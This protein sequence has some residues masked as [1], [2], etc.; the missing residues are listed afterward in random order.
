MIFLITCCPIMLPIIDFSPARSV[1][2]MIQDACAK[3]MPSVEVRMPGAQLVDGDIDELTYEEYERSF[4]RKDAERIERC[5]R[6]IEPNVLVLLPG[7]A[8]DVYFNDIESGLSHNVDVWDERDAAMFDS[9][10]LHLRFHK[11]KHHTSIILR[12]R[13]EW[14]PRSK[15]M[16][17]VTTTFATDNWNIVF[18][19]MYAATRE[20]NTLSSV[21]TYMELCRSGKFKKYASNKHVVEAINT[22]L[23]HTRKH[24]V[25]LPDEMYATY[26]NRPPTMPANVT[27]VSEAFLSFDPTVHDLVPVHRVVDSSELEARYGSIDRFPILEKE[28]PISKWYGFTE[29]QIVRIDRNNAGVVDTYYRR[30]V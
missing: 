7:T 14:V 5:I 11:I 30:V 6:E 9:H 3:Y 23:S 27:V 4:E 17:T 10:E 12:N 25:I 26:E 29:G 21:N 18:G 24:L 13:G 20:G 22:S 2:R 19:W 1:L 28:D 15:I 8:Y 16:A